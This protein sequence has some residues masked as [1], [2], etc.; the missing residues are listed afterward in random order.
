MC[1]RSL[2]G[3]AEGVLEFVV[4]VGCS[5]GEARRDRDGVLLRLRPS[6]IEIETSKMG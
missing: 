6:A 1:F 2:L 5:T 4:V 3:E